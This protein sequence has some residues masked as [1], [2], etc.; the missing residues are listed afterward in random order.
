MVSGRRQFS[1]CCLITDFFLN[2]ICY[3]GAVVLHMSRTGN[4]GYDREVWEIFP[5]CSPGAFRLC[6]PSSI[7]RPLYSYSP[8]HAGALTLI[9]AAQG[10]NCIIPCCGEQCIWTQ[11]RP[12]LLSICDIVSVSTQAKLLPEPCR[13]GFSS[14]TFDARPKPKTFRLC[15]ALV[16]IAC[17]QFLLSNGLL[18]FRWSRRRCMTHSTSSQTPSHRSEC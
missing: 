15:E 1:S 18:T 4:C 7:L 9:F 6:Q 16:T 11:S 8:T 10:F 2:C 14:W 5:G 12:L 17:K 3:A 13:C